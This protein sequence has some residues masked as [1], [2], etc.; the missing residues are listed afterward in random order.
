MSNWHGN[1]CGKEETMTEYI[2]NWAR[3]EW[4]ALEY[5]EK[6]VEEA[7]DYEISNDYLDNEMVWEQLRCLFT[8]W[9]LMESVNVDTLPCDWMLRKLYEAFHPTISLEDFADYMIKYI[10]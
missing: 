4:D 10:V 9:C 1:V 6:E 5:Y 8:S 3:E 2:L 7:D